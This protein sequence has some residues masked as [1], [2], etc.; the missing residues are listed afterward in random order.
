MVNI[1]TH[2]SMTSSGF[3][4]GLRLC[5][6]VLVILKVDSTEYCW[7]YYQCGWV[8]GN[9][10]ELMIKG[11]MFF[12]LYIILYCALQW[13][14]QHLSPLS[15]DL[16][17]MYCLAL[18]SCALLSTLLVFSAACARFI[19]L[20]RKQPL[21]HSQGFVRSSCKVHKFWKLWKSMSWEHIFFLSTW[22]T[23]VSKNVIFH[24]RC[25][26]FKLHTCYFAYRFIIPSPMRNM[27]GAMMMWIQS[28]HLQSMSWKREW[29]KWMYS[30]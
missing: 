10:R 26:R 11:F 25:K 20:T 18:P 1:S 7:I 3:Q 24:K 21:G 6:V 28:Q 8:L 29:R 4:R 17:Y 2:F 12:I 19:I 9:E 16:C 27:I 30:L 23:Y 15:I 13:W 22:F 5:L 14:W